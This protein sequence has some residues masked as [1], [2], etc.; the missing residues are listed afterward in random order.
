MKGLA[1]KA[2]RTG[3][4]VGSV[5]APQTTG[6]VALRL[7][8]TPFDPMGPNARK[9]AV[10]EEGRQ[11]FAAAESHRIPFGAGHVQ[12]YRFMPDPAQDRG[13]TVALVHGWANQAYFMRSFAADLVQAG[14]RVLAFDLPAH[15][16]SSGRVTD[17]FDSARAL[18]ALA[19]ELG[20]LHGIVAYSFGGAVTAVA[21]EGT[22]PLAGPVP[23]SRIALV[24]VP[25]AI[26]DVTRRFGELA[27]LGPR[28]QTSFEDQLT[29]RG[30]RSLDSLRVGRI[31]AGSGLPF[32]VVHSRDDREIPFADGEKLAD[33]GGNGVLYP[34]DGLGHRRILYAPEVT[35]RIT[36][37]MMER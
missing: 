31:L 28:A 17:P 25:N 20:P 7:F 2:L 14:F 5:L 21:I 6:R 10:V 32:L 26:E 22:A 23:A 19:A 9:Q 36:S 12:A 34:V 15:G 37:F 18:H 35:G 30:G 16:D 8:R 24:S 3:M 29:S 13:E 11:A 1:F 27:G 4:Q 33:A